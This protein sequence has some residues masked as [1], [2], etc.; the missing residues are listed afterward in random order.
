MK[1]QRL[2]LK[3]DYVE[4]VALF[5]YFMS[6]LAFPLLNTSYEYWYISL[7]LAICYV[8]CHY[9]EN[10]CGGHCY[11]SADSTAAPITLICAGLLFGALYIKGLEKGE[12]IVFLYV[13]IGFMVAHILAIACAALLS[14]FDKRGQDK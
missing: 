14:V 1:Y 9:Y 12:I 7:P 6:W 8:C 5:V 13:A 11:L 3:E 4:I 10:T 2:S